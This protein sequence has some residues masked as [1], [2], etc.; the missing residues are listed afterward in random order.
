[1]VELPSLRTNVVRGN[2]RTVLPS[3][4]GI[5]DSAVQLVLTHQRVPVVVRACGFYNRSRAVH[6]GLLYTPCGVGADR[7]M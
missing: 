4:V 6:T 1:V 2:L 7:L 3:T 5:K